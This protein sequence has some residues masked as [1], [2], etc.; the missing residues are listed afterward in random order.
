MIGVRSSLETVKSC[1][2]LITILSTRRL[3]ERGSGARRARFRRGVA[4]SS[5]VPVGQGAGPSPSNPNS[6]EEIRATEGMEINA[7]QQSM[8]GIDSPEGKRGLG[9]PVS[10]IFHQ[11]LGGKGDEAETHLNRCLRL[12]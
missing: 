7:T 11:R 5:S 3:E 1:Q 12:S 4:V 10:G 9:R 2:A 8:M 6:G